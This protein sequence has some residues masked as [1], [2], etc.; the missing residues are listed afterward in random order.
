M[1]HFLLIDTSTNFANIGLADEKKIIV[2]YS[3][4]SRKNLSETL[5]VEIEKLFKKIKFEP[6]ELSGII[7]YLGPGSY[8]GLRV[9][10]TT[11]NTFA[12]S[13]KIPI[14]GIKGKSF[15]KE[16]FEL[17]EMKPQDLQKLFTSGLGEIQNKKAGESVTPFYGKEPNIG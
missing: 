7:I 11:A 15:G 16:K 17:A 9:G 4:D 3:W 14:V 6:E 5:L 12:Y 10:V 13:L 8:T 1:K 2:S